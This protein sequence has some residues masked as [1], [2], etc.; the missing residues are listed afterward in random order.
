MDEFQLSTNQRVRIACLKA[1]REILLEGLPGGEEVSTIDMYSL[2]SYIEN[3]Q[4]PYD[5]PK[6]SA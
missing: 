2:A 5:T 6:E 3:G 1:A 4:D